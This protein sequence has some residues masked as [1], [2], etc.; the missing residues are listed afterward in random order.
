[1][2]STRILRRPNRKDYNLLVQEICDSAISEHILC[3]WTEGNKYLVKIL[4][5]AK[6]LALTELEYN[7]PGKLLLTPTDA[8]LDGN[9]SNHDRA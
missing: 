9:T 2:I 7:K 1:M 5:Y 6:Y 8:C 3:Q 4:G